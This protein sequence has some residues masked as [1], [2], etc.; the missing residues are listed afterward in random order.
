MIKNLCKNCP[1]ITELDIDYGGSCWVK[2]NGYKCWAKEKTPRINEGQICK[3]C[4]QI[5]KP[6]SESKPPTHPEGKR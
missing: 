2:Q 1:K 6:L 5:I 3:L 4:G